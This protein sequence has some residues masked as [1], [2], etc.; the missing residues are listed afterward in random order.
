[1]ER[2]GKRLL[3]YQLQQIES[4]T[5]ESSEKHVYYSQLQILTY[6]ASYD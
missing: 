2:Y 3:N 1:M 5:N 4:I 6:T